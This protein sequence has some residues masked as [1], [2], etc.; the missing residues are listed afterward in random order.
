MHGAWR[1]LAAF[2]AA[3]ECPF[4]RAFRVPP[5]YGR[6]NTDDYLCGWDTSPPL[7]PIA[8]NFQ[9]GYNECIVGE[10]R[11]RKPL[12]DFSQRID[13]AIHHCIR[14]ITPGTAPAVW[15]EIL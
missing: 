4:R 9:T 15:E 8:K 1:P 11:V 14:G 2:F 12:P 5:P 3:G 13:H 7:C 6:E 10:V